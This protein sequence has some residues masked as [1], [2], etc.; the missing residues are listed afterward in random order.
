MSE[1]FGFYI[2]DLSM[3]AEAVLDGPVIFR[4][5]ACETENRCGDHSVMASLALTRERLCP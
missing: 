3:G 1:G 2:A 4:R 5:N